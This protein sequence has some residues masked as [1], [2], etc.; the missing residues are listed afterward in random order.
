MNIPQLPNDII[1]KILNH[2]KEI[3]YLDRKQEEAQINKHI[4]NVE[5]NYLI[6]DM[7]DSIQMMLDNN[8]MDEEETAEFEKLTFI[9]LIIEEIENFNQYNNLCRSFIF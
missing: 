8:E 1:I 3:K 9:D 6:N 4:L 5:F 7:Y 2:R